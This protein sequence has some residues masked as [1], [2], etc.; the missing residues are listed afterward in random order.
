MGTGGAELSEMDQ[1]NIKTNQ[2]TVTTNETD[3]KVA[4][5][6]SGQS[7]AGTGQGKVAAGDGT[8]VTD[9]VI[10]RAREIR[11]EL[12]EGRSS[13]AGLVFLAN[14]ASGLLSGT[15]SKAGVGEH[16]KFLVKL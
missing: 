16:L 8:P 13:Q 9:D 5:T 4:T 2:G 3:Q 7:G 15:T 1:G 12:A 10:A 11:N 14:L 6:D